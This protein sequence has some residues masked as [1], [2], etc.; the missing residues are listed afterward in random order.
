MHQDE[1]LKF[2]SCRSDFKKESLC[3]KESCWGKK[4][5][6]NSPQPAHGL[7]PWR[8]VPTT[9]L[10]MCLHVRRVCPRAGWR[11]T[12]VIYDLS[13][14]G[15]IHGDM[16]HATAPPPQINKHFSACITASMHV[17]IELLQK[18]LCRVHHILPSLPPLLYFDNAPPSL[19]F[20]FPPQKTYK[21]LILWTRFFFSNIVWNW[22]H[23]EA[24]CSVAFRGRVTD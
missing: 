1:F 22:F 18:L 9:Y 15:C 12:D 2:G 19:F 14:T 20:F 23:G 10:Y 21:T 24:G 7:I 17:L 4:Q 8:R 11:F 5:Q 6:K 3:L 16:R 13:Y